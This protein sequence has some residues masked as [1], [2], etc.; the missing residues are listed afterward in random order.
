MDKKSLRL[1]D[2]Y[3]ELTWCTA[4]GNKFIRTL[5]WQEQ[6]LA[7]DLNDIEYDE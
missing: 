3:F 2:G 5:E 6:L 1:Q 7:A 4:E